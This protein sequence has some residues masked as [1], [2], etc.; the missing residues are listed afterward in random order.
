MDI[1]RIIRFDYGDAVYAKLAKEAY[2]LWTSS[3]LY[4][5]A[6]H[7]TPFALTAANPSGRAYVDKCTQSLDTLGLPWQSMQDAMDA[8]RQFPALSGPLAQPDFHGY[9]NR[10]AGWA[11]SQQAIA[12][13]RDRCL[14]AG[15][16]FICGRRGTVTELMTESR[17][18]KIH[19]LRTLS[20]DVIPGDIFILAAGAWSSSLV[21]MYNTTLSTAQ[22]LAFMK[23]ND[24]E[25]KRYEDLPI[26]MNFSSGF[27]CFPTHPQT[28]YLKFVI[29][30]LGYTRTETESTNAGER[31]VSV[32]R[33]QRPTSDSKSLSTPPWMPRNQRSNFA[34]ED[35]LQ[36]LRAGVQEALPELA[37]REFDLAT[38]C[39]YT[40][41]PTGDFIVDYHKDYANLFLA[42][43]G[44][45]Q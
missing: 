37:S 8:R 11:D 16:S 36:R 23:M 30:G 33:E 26:Y 6:F 45:G 31:E 44:S 34:P 40:D 15:V 1:S 3:P 38:T 29:H 2:D 14:E 5:Q 13:L 12:L 42:T 21:P 17:S 10:Q 4:S 20:N 35:G 9:V 22:V 39:W 18:R 7:S 41:T 19:A 24:V 28:G 27:F 25:M 43:G 32:A